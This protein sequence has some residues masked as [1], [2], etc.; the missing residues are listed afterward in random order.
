[1]SLPRALY[2][3]ALLPRSACHP[4]RV[5]RPALL[6]RL[7]DALR[8]DAD[9][10][11]PQ[12]QLLL[13]PRG[14]GKSMLLRCLGHAIERDE[15]LAETWLPLTFPEAQYDVAR[16]SDLWLNCL[17]Y[18]AVALTRR[19]ERVA[20]N[21]VRNA[22]AELF[23]LDEDARAEEAFALLVAEAAALGRRFV[24]LIDN[25]DV[26]LDRLKERHW[27]VRDILSAEEQLV[28]IGA[29]ARA[30]E[31]TYAYDAAFY[32][33]FRLHE[34]GPLSPENVPD[35]LDLLTPQHVDSRVA[36]LVPKHVLEAVTTLVGTQPRSLTVLA[37]ALLS[38][39]RTPA[40]LVAT[41]LDA[42]T[43]EFQA[44][45]DA[46]TPGSQRLLHALGTGWHPQSVAEIARSLRISSQQSGA[47]LAR[48]AR[49]G[50]ATWETLPDG[51]RGYL[52]AD[53]LFAVWFMLRAGQPHRRR[54]L[55]TAA[56]LAALGDRGAAPDSTLAD[57]RQL[58]VL[59]RFPEAR[60]HALPGLR[61]A[62]EGL[63]AS[64]VAGA[65]GFL[66]AA[67]GFGRTNDGLALLAEVDVPG[68]WDLVRRALEFAENP[69]S[70][71]LAR[72]A[73]ELRP[74]LRALARIQFSPSAV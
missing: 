46:M 40:D 60:R 16:P 59:G 2:N 26:V 67:I 22:T 32:D 74:P 43:P 8:R 18:L 70:D 9:D 61:R 48:L 72:T 65:L 10:P 3:P 55:D 34:L 15:E 44:R 14:A 19:G 11:L 58:V 12:H 4:T 73:P 7:I 6:S 41:V 57:A 20:A 54:L 42:L 5:V 47:A 25:I 39:L 51:R 35:A 28:V 17:D 63:D 21:E 45:V 66:E 64:A 31:S 27:L 68:R 1:M 23:D 53:R 69:G 62:V 56:L 52:L 50:V 38:G 13:G 49:D 29:S 33:F 71:V 30:L 37:D 36:D 24:L